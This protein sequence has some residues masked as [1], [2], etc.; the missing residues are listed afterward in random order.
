[1]AIL[2]GLLGAITLGSVVLSPNRAGFTIAGTIAAVVFVVLEANA[3]RPDNRPRV[4]LV[5]G[6][7]LVATFMCGIS[8]PGL[9]HGLFQGNGTVQSLEAL[10]ETW[11]MSGFICGLAGWSVIYTARKAWLRGLRK[12]ERS[13]A[14]ERLFGPDEGD[15]AGLQKPPTTK[16]IP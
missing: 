3:P 11:L 1:M 10:W 6:A 5:T 16:L 14:A 8:L 9:F 4:W 7:K 12:I 15:V 13:K 2:A